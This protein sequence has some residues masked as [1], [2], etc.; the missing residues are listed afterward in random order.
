MR[1]VGGPLLVLALL[2]GGPAFGQSLP[3]AAHLYGQPIVSLSIDIEGVRTA[4]PALADLIETHRGQ[5]LEARAVR[6]SITHLF[7]LGRFEDVRVHADAA[8]GGVAL[9]YELMP[10]HSVRRIEFAGNLGLDE[11][12][13]RRAITESVGISPSAARA[14]DLVKVLRNLYTDTG[15][16]Q[17]SI[18]TRRVVR[19]APEE[20]VLVFDVDAGPRLRLGKVTVEGNFP[21]SLAQARERLGFAAGQFYDR[22]R[23][24]NQLAELLDDLHRRGYYEAT[25]EHVL[26]D[27][28]RDKR[29][30][31]LVIT[32]DGGPHITIEF[33]GDPVPVKVRDELVPIAREGTVDEDLLEDSSRRIADYFHGQG[34]RD[35]AVT[36][37]RAPRGD[38]LAI[39][40]RV[41]RGPSYR[42]GSVLVEGNASV[43]LDVLMPAVRLPAG[44]PFVESRLDAAVA[45][46]TDVYQRR[47][48]TAVK[49]DTAVIPGSGTPPIDATIRIHIQEGPKTAVGS[50]SLAGNR[51]IPDAVLRRGL[52]AVPG[53]PL[54]LP[55]LA[56]D[57]DGIL[58]KYLN[59]GYRT[60]EVDVAQAFSADHTRVDLTYTIRE[61][62]QVF[63]DHVLVVGNEK[64][65]TDTIR[66]EVA[67]K[68]GDP[69]GN[70]AVVESQRRVSALGLF[71][72]VR[73]TELDT[74]DDTHRD[75]LV[76]VDEAPAT[77]IG[78]GG[79]GEVGR[80]VVRTAVDQTPS[81]RFEFAPRGFFEVGR[82]NLFGRNR[83]INLFTRVSLRLRGASV[84]T[85]D[86]EQPSADFNE[87]RILGTYRQPR[88][89]GN[90]DFVATGYAEQGARTSFDFNRRG[91][92][93]EMA[94][95]LRPTLTVIGRYSLER[96]EVF[97]ETVTGQD[98]LIIDRLF[99]QV[100][101]SILSSSVIKDTR[102][103][104]LF[105]TRGGLF[106]LDSEFAA[107]SVGSEVGFVKSFVQGFVYRTLPGRRNV[108][109]A[110]GARVG[111]AAG[112]A[113]LAQQVD[114]NGRPVVGPD[115]QPVLEVVDDLPASERFFAGGDT[116]VRGFALDQLGT[117][118]TLDRNG[119]PK[120]G[121]AVVVLNAE[122]RFPV[123]HDL[124][125]VTFVDAGNV[126]ANLDDVALGDIRGTMGV[127][128]RY[129][130][131]IG[132]LRF[133]VGF[134]MDRRVLPNGQREK[135]SALYVSLGQA[136]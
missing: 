25:A 59:R 87:Y 86:G 83:S 12:R 127:G 77:T 27:V 38:E 29:S 117:P 107:R 64:T 135:P 47:G 63:V 125:G 102:D 114:E 121:N 90:N 123:W 93:V 75:L 130:S 124:G 18:R 62:P 122:L 26:K 126:F 65:S 34:Y 79:G 44:E 32:L 41:R 91:A 71:R 31:E 57:R 46:L 96:A 88:L 45:A 17:A 110:T 105:P 51:A 16:L 11:G 106:G 24:V 132:P 49:I 136:F 100:R 37:T 84:L 58:L 20:T 103:D 129:R 131:P 66:R 19:H 97:N 133:D 128:L 92:R 1:R 43:P 9:R 7:S 5:R 14:G 118:E 111:L 10:T 85:N 115:G 76:S 33:Q 53:V 30:A 101:L 69:L 50:V 119:F 54:Y 78:Y 108:V 56:V 42:V 35:A 80:R 116:T 23:V 134:K 21:G 61:G 6:E 3:V 2:A 52:V 13:L 72:R 74:G 60:A 81:E 98:L 94:R 39:I 120:G 89:F 113:R 8:P 109:L 22:T 104:P 15:F 95:R 55:Q 112:F 82:R 67:L 48:F 70:D 40:F 4:D 68:P 99:P 36:Y 73:I 28:S